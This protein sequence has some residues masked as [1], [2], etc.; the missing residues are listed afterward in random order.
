MPPLPKFIC[1]VSGNRVDLVT[2]GAETEGKAMPCFL[3]AAGLWKTG[4]FASKKAAGDWYKDCKD[5]FLKGA[6]VDEVRLQKL[7]GS[8]V[9]NF[10]VRSPHGWFSDQYYPD[11]SRASFAFGLG[12]APV[13]VEVIGDPDEFKDPGPTDGLGPETDDPDPDELLA[14]AKRIRRERED[15]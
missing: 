3:R 2:V 4:L 11:S 7:V 10:M 1:P 8:P 15:G 9:V 12:P 6:T 5:N 13:K 14:E